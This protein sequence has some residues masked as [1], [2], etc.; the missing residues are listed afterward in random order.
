[1]D[2]VI[3]LFIAIAIFCA[4][5]QYT[6]RTGLVLSAAVATKL[7]PVLL[8]PLFLRHSRALK[9]DRWRVLLT[10]TAFLTLICIP[11]LWAIPLGKKSGFIAYGQRWEMNDALFMIF[12]K[13]T[14]LAATPFSI[15]DARIDTI[16]RLIVGAVLLIWIYYLSRNRQPRSADFFN[17]LTLAAA[18]LFMLSPTQ[19]PWYYLWILPLLTLAPRNSLLLLTTM[20]PLYYLKFYFIA[21]DQAN[22]FHN[23]IVWIEFTPTIIFLL[24]EAWTSK[25]DLR[26][27][28]KIENP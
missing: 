18:A 15:P 7:W 1:M 4:V 5:Q 22:V 21:K 9:D 25:L 3:M 13:L 6:L 24:H 8:V 19:Y 26:P 12:D 14:H 10:S 11:M 2:P 16:T 27:P 20:L 28:M 23:A 17:R